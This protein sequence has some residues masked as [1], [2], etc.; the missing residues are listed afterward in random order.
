MIIN[1]SNILKQFGKYEKQIPEFIQNAPK[2]FIQEFINGYMNANTCNNNALQITTVSLNLAYSLQR[3]YLKLGNIFSINKYVN[4]I[5]IL[6]K[7]C[8][9]SSFIEDNYV[10]FKP[11][12][13]TKRKT[14]YT[15]V[16]NFEI[17][18]DNSYIIENII[19]HNCQLFSQCGKHKGFNDE[20][21]TLFFNIMKFV[22]YHKPKVII[23]ENV[24]DY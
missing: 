16:Y 15:T 7:E 2:E 6:Q 3:L 12:I 11:C 13:I 14:I 5:Y 4:N 21:G 23:L 8:N 24:M 17:E 18:N 19:V 22:D 10:W 9:I 1:I 20:R